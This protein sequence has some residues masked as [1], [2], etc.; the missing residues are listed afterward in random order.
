MI[1]KLSDW[2]LRHRPL[3]LKRSKMRRLLPLPLRLL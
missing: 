1:Q 3:L 2:Q